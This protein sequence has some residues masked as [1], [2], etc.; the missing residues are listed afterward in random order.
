MFYATVLF[1]KLENSGKAKK[2]NKT[3]QTALPLLPMSR[4][5]AL[6]L[7]SKSYQQVKILIA[8]LSWLA[9]PC[10]VS[11]FSLAICHETQYCCKIPGKMVLCVPRIQKILSFLHPFPSPPS[12]FKI[13][14][15]FH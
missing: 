6:F 8:A 4:P 5:P 10:T 9:V 2:Q 15:G 11:W 3:K 12:S 13:R 7:F 14:S 1:L